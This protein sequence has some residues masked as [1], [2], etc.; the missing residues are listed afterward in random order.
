MV[1]A[2]GQGAPRVT[3]NSSVYHP[4]PIMIQPQSW[5]CWYTSFQMVV[6]YERG[7]GRGERLLD[8]SEVGWVQ[9]IYDRN[10]GIGTVPDERER[11]AQALGFHVL[12][13]SLT[14]DGM[15]ELLRDVPLI[16][17][18]RWPNQRSGHW[19]V[20]VG[21]SGDTIVINDPAEGQTTHDY[22]WFAGEV[23]LQSAERPLIHPPR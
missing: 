1:I 15:W 21:I 19:V 10:E 18:G 22:N 5:A 2:P 6:A 11:V 8:P 14:A 17:A 9:A 3:P 13:A 16:Y 12:Y 7:R 20:P 23:L 4:V